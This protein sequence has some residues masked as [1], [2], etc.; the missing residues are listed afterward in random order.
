LFLL[1]MACNSP[2]LAVISFSSLD[3]LFFF[4]WRKG[5]LCYFNKK[6]TNN[7]FF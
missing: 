5:L 1:F 7:S 2:S 3:A 4:D 6:L